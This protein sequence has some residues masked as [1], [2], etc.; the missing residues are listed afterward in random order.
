MTTNPPKPSPKILRSVVIVIALVLAGAASKHFSE[1][2]GELGTGNGIESTKMTEEEPNARVPEATGT[3]S[4]GDAGSA[5]GAWG[6]VTEATLT[7]VIDGDTIRTDKGR[8]RIIGIDSPEREQCGYEDARQTVL[9]LVS[10]GEPVTLVLPEGMDDTDRYN[11]L[12]RYV[13]TEEGVDVGLAQLEAGNAVARYDSTENHAYHPK[14]AAY[15]E[16]QI[17]RLTNDR[18]VIT[19]SCE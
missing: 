5:P 19:T 13:Y 16:A 1:D 2:E 8:V 18:E 15:H 3:D 6:Q 12:L 11:R 9:D 7:E 17:A 4:N 14:E 10:V